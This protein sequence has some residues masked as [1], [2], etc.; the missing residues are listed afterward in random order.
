MLQQQQQQ[1]FVG[2]LSG[3]TQLSWY[4]KKTFTYL[5]WG[6]HGAVDIGHMRLGFVVQEYNNRGSCNA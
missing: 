3:T 6:A 5:C 4:Q 1:L 2:P